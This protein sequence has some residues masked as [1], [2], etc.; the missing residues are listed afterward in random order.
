MTEEAADVGFLPQGIK[1]V[2]AESYERIH[3]SNLVGMGVIPLEYLPGDSAES[4]GLSGRERFSVIIPPQLTPRMTVDIKVEHMIST[5]NWA[6][7]QPLSTGFSSGNILH[8]VTSQYQCTTKM[9]LK[10]KPNMHSFYRSYSYCIRPPKCTINLTF[11]SNK[12]KGSLSITYALHTCSKGFF[13]VPRPTVQQE[14]KPTVNYG[15]THT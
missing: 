15:H 2:L 7:N 5:T 10:S 9:T 1:A 13:L 6:L 14:T 11:C 12:V 3:R 8:Q 4:L